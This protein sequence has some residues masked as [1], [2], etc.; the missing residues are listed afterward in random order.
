[1]VVRS[2]L[3]EFRQA[4]AAL[5]TLVRAE[6]ADLFGTLD[7]SRPEAARDALLEFVPALTEEYGQSAAGLAAEWYE[8]QRAASGATGAFRATMAPSVPTSAVQSQVR[9]QAGQLW[10]PTPEAALSALLTSVDKFVKQP[11]RD[12]VRTN[13]K[14]EGVRWARVPKGTKTCA[15]CLFLA[16]R[17]AVYVSKK[18]AGDLGKGV[19]DDFHGHCD[20]A[21]VRISKASDYPK[22]YLPDNYLSMYETAVDETDSPEVRAFIESLDPDDKNKQLKAAAFV[23]RREFPDAIR[24]S[25]HAP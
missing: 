20:C 3:E 17:D 21:V 2:D 24:D 13:A 22:D 1:M 8:E 12:T 14:R 19:G 11:G 4:N 9:Y 10:T 25:V 6:L 18:A 15:F 7:L 16:S 5:S 23:L